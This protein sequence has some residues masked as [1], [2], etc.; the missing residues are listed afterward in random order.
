MVVHINIIANNIHGSMGITGVTDNT[1]ITH[2]T[3]IMGNT[4]NRN[5]LCWN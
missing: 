3:G 4:G 2:N 5:P 1:G